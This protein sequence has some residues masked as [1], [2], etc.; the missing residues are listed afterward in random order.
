M[1]SSGKRS[2]AK[3]SR[4]PTSISKILTPQEYR[5]ILP[6]LPTARPYRIDDFRDVLKDIVDTKDVAGFDA[7]QYNHVWML[8]LH[9]T[10]GVNVKGETWL[11]IDPNVSEK[12]LNVHWVA[13][14]VPYG[15]AQKTHGKGKSNVREKWRQP[16]FENVETTT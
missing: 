14:C 15:A 1:S 13:A 2:A 5:I 10:A 12:S 4:V 9:N 16:G 6:T 8:T 11:V 3:P 7:F